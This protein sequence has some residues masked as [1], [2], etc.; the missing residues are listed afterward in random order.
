V[1]DSVV[2]QPILTK[3]DCGTGKVWAT[4]LDLGT[5]ETPQIYHHCD[6]ST[7]HKHSNK[8]GGNL[9]VQYERQKK[10]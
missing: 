4:M 3:L 8:G 6:Q 1:S 9:F 5:S 7:D 2:L 10:G